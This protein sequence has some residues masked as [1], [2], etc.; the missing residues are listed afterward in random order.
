MSDLIADREI[1]DSKDCGPASLKPVKQKIETRTAQIGEG[2]TI[3]RALPHPERRMIGAWCFF[4]HFGPV[5]L[6]TSNGLNIAPHPHMGLQT[7]T[8]VI[9]GQILHRDSLGFQQIIQP[10]QVNLMTAGNG[11]SHSEETVPD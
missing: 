4:D 8:W 10:G 11:I 3:R 1:S 2:L 5:N 6:K 7:F 9:A